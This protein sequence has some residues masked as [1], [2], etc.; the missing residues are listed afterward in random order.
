MLAVSTSYFFGP[1]VHP[2]RHRLFRT[3]YGDAS[4]IA[5]GRRLLSGTLAITPDIRR[6]FV[7]S[8]YVTVMIW[9]VFCAATVHIYQ[10]EWTAMFVLLSTAA[11]TAG[12]SSGLAP[13][14]TLAKPVPF[15]IN[16]AHDYYRIALTRYRICR[17]RHLDLYI[18]RFSPGADTEQLVG[19]LEREC[20]RRAGTNPGFG[21]AQAGGS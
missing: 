20:R 17:I 15:L 2:G 18:S 16:G 21:G 10:R 8:I 6:Y 13:N 12:A 7:G 5:A 1:S 19:L 3:D 4:E 14:L 11:L 9:G